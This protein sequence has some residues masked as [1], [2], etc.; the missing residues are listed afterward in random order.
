LL[1][2]KESIKCVFFN[3]ITHFLIGILARKN[4]FTQQDASTHLKMFFCDC[5]CSTTKM[6]TIV[7]YLVQSGFNN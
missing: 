4:E 6:Y 5:H 7:Q 1:S 2:I 3:M